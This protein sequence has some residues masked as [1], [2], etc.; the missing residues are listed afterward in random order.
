MNQIMQ[1]LMLYISKTT[2]K[3]CENI[4]IDLLQEKLNSDESEVADLVEILIREHVLREKYT[5]KCPECGELNTV[6][7]GHIG[8]NECQ[9]CSAT[10]DVVKM[11]EGATIRYILDREDF[12]EYMQENYKKEYELAKRGEEPSLKVVSFSPTCTKEE[13]VV[14]SSEKTPRL[15]ISHSSKDLAY[16]KAFVE[17]LEDLR[18]PEGSVFCSSVE[19]YNINWG[20]DIYDY[21]SSE[22]ND[23]EKNLIVLFMLSE[24]YYESAPCLNEMGATWVLKKDYRSILLPG[25]EYKQIEGAINPN[26]IGIKMDSPNLKM[27]LNGVKEQFEK[28]FNFTAPTG[29]IWDRIRDDFIEKIKNASQEE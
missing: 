1:K 19:G 12:Y 3:Q 9:I 25:F 2:R 7:K 6:I 14:E 11:L 10:I 13:E 20:A 23:G 18:M 26:K 21:L 28:I 15:F 29:S 5:F 27:E 24:N 22:F 16:V 17:F 4:T 8:N